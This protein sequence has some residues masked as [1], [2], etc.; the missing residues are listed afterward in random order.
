MDDKSLVTPDMLKIEK[1][2]VL[3]KLPDPFTFEDGRKVK[4]GSDWPEEG[5]N[6]TSR[7]SNFSTA[8][9][10]PRPNLPKSKRCTTAEK[11]AFIR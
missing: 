6:F 10:R 2:E 8:F 5:K 9:N 4:T 3:G 11:R 1:Y 7:L